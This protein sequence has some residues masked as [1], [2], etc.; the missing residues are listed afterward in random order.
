MMGIESNFG[1]IIEFVFLWHGLSLSVFCS[2][3]GF[4]CFVPSKVDSVWT[5][6]NGDTKGVCK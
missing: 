4:N 2:K 5:L 6:F 3:G 1:Q